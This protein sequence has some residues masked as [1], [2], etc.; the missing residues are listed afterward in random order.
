[1]T[2]FK[3]PYPVNM[4]FTTIGFKV[5]ELYAPFRHPCVN[6]CLSVLIKDKLLASFT[7][8]SFRIKPAAIHP[9]L[10]DI[11]KPHHNDGIVVNRR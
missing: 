10:I 5:T 7:D 3:I 1:M 8:P 2:R 6:L 11:V 9:R 4:P